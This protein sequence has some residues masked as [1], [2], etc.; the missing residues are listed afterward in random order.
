MPTYDSN[1]KAIGE[2]LLDPNNYRFR[3]EEDYIDVA[4]HRYHEEL[5]QTRA[6]SKLRD[7]GLTELKNSILKNGFI[8]VEPI[9]I[10][11]YT[12]ADNFFVVIE[13]N[14]RLAALIWIKRDIDGGVDYNDTII[15]T[16]EN[17]PVVLVQNDEDD[18]AF[19][20][21]LM[22][23]RHVSGIKQ[24]GGYQRANLVVILKDEKGLD[25]DEVADRLGMSTRE[26]NRRYKAFKALKQMKEEE[27]F[28]EHAKPNLYAIFHEAVSVTSIKEWLEW[29]ESHF[30]FVNEENR[31]SFYDLIT[32][33]DP[34]EVGFSEPKIRTFSDARE[35]RYILANDEAKEVL[36]DPRRS[37]VDALAIAKE[38]QISRAW[39]T[40]I[41]SA[42]EALD[43]IGFRDLRNLSSDDITLLQNLSALANDVIASHERLSQDR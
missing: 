15:H 33:N 40:K 35:L 42:F 20:E 11:P 28:G 7:A 41:N 4:A 5:V 19:F 17:I 24:W 14:R 18:P 34:D 23:V 29:D 2:L 43:S 3:D 22:G 27:D 31:R 9:V 1:T 32:P 21:A 37:F 30:I 13:G 25:S 8:P 10:K 12:H 39:R 36:L 16:L 6:W 38:E 26:V